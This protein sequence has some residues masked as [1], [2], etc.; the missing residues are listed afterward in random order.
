MGHKK[1]VLEEVLSRALHAD[2]TEAYTVTYR[3]FNIAREVKLT[4]FLELSENF[5]TI[6]ASRII[7]VK[8]EEKK[9]YRNSRKEM[10]DLLKGEKSRVY[11]EKN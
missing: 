6:P 9:L 4:E 11:R 2:K 1:G 5:Q 10:I 7:L 3:E 8:R